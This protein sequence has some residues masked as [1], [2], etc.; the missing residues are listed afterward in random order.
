MKR[1]VRISGLHVLLYLGKGP[2]AVFERKIEDHIEVDRFLMCVRSV[3][4]AATASS[5]VLRE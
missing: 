4:S 5:D 1:V 2:G 3:R